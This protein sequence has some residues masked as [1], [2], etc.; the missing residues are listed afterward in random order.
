MVLK[1]NICFI[2]ESLMIFKVKP[3]FKILEM[4]YHW[5]CLTNTTFYGFS[6]CFSEEN[7]SYMYTTHGLVTALCTENV[8]KC[9]G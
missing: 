5:I 9:C 6:P 4:K 7:D 2:S 3:I 8:D 1:I